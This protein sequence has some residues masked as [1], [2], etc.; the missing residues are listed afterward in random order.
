MNKCNKL[1]H[2]MYW[3][4]T[5]ANIHKSS[6]KFIHSSNF[7][8]NLNYPY[9]QSTNPTIHTLQEYSANSVEH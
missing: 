1:E 2:S 4:I 9:L 5:E 3:Q 6:D 8:G 7:L